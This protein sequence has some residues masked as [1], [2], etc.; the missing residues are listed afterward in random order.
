MAILRPSKFDIPDHPHVP[1]YLAFDQDG[2]RI[3]A[4]QNKEYAIEMFERVLQ[5]KPQ[6][7]MAVPYYLWNK[8]RA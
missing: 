2:K 5:A 7:V 6:G 3:I 8:N 1:I 4:S